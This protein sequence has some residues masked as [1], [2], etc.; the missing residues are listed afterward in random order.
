MTSRVVG[1]HWSHGTG[2]LRRCPC[3]DCYLLLLVLLLL[4]CCFES[5]LS[6]LLELSK[7]RYKNYEEHKKYDNNNKN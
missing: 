2:S 6:R 5:D 7:E 4:Y 1:L 3:L